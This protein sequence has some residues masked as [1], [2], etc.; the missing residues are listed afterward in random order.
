MQQET[1]SASNLAGVRP[2]PMVFISHDSRDAD[3]A[4]AFANLL[5]DATGGVLRSFRSSDRKGTAGIEFGAEWYSAIM[6][7]LKG[8]T[9]VVALLTAQSLGRPWL[10]YEAGVAKGRLDSVV[11]G[12]ALGVPLENV[13]I[14]PFAQFQNSGD[15]EDSLTKLVLQ[16]IR[17]N[18]DADPREEAV[19]RQ[20]SVFRE[21]SAQ[22]LAKRS[23]PGVTIRSAEPDASAVA[24]LFEEVKVMFRQLPEQLEMSLERRLSGMRQHRSLP[25]G[26][27]GRTIDRLYRSLT[28]SAPGDDAAWRKVAALARAALPGS[29]LRQ[30][31]EM[32]HAWREEE[33]DRISLAAERLRE[34]LLSNRRPDLSHLPR[35]YGE[36]LQ[37]LVPMLIAVLERFYVPPVP[38]TTPTKKADT[39]SA[40]AD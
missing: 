5:Q 1:L 35:E 2:K 33:P 30:V 14:G 32:R 16:L 22:I 40:K 9:D 18:P 25:S 20:V 23:A 12:V 6:E 38:S 19:R 37:D 26:I 24:R 11:F 15:D 13:G 3:L 29:I 21:T 4:E 28:E 10:L 36:H 27:D 17:R 8:A 7:K 34:V 31:T 39:K